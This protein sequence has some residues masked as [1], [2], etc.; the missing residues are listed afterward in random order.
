MTRRT[1]IHAFISAIAPPTHA[2]GCPVLPSATR[3]SVSVAYS[4]IGVASTES[5]WTPR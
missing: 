4:A 2:V 3:I 1:T 5:A